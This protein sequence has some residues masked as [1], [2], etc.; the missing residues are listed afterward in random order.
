MWIH[1]RHVLHS[2][3]WW[4]LATILLQT[5]HL[6]QFLHSKVASG[7]LYC[8]IVTLLHF[9]CIHLLHLLHNIALSF[10]LI[11]ISQIPH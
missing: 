8:L 4:F 3:A 7:F 5:P 10:V 11:I 9:M 2:I 6:L 1:L